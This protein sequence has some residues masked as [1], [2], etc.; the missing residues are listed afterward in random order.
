[1]VAVWPNSRNHTQPTGGEMLYLHN[2]VIRAGRN[3]AMIFRYET[4]RAHNNLIGGT[5]SWG[6]I[7]HHSHNG[8]LGR[9]A[10]QSADDGWAPGEASW[11]FPAGPRGGDA[12]AEQ[13]ASV[14]R[15]A[16]AEDAERRDYRL[17]GRQDAN[18]AIHA[19]RDVR[20]VL[21][22]AGVLDAFPDFDFGVD[23]ARRPWS[24]RPSM[25]AYEYG[26]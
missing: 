14:F 17:A 1:M 10:K 11:Q 13:I 6:A 20:E 5:A 21:R 8:W 22:A 7:G 23:I 4:H 3:I 18:P 26:E 19:G 25:G 2:T 16:L 24:A 12:T 9:Y 15:D